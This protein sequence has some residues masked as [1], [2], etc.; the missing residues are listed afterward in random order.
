MTET[1]QRKKTV[2]R[3]GCESDTV[4]RVQ[5]VMPQAGNQ[6]DRVA[7]SVENASAKR[8]SLSAL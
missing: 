8:D 7:A 6:S 5:H 3:R 1:S 2:L 4:E